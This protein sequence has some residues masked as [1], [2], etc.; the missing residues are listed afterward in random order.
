MK[1]RIE[2]LSDPVLNNTDYINEL[3][4]NIKLMRQIQ[5]SHLFIVNNIDL[6]IHM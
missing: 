6:K 4:K 2:L 5:T 1:T 3:K